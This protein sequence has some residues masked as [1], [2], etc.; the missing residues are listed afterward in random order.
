MTSISKESNTVLCYM[1]LMKL[2]LN[3]CW[4]SGPSFPDSGK[5]FADDNHSYSQDLDIFGSN[6]LF[7]MINTATTYR[8][9]NVLQGFLADRPNSVDEIYKRQEAVSELAP[10][11]GWRQRFQAEALSTSGSMGDPEKL[12]KWAGDFN[13]KYRNPL[14]YYNYQACSCVYTYSLRIILCSAPYSLLSSCCCTHCSVHSSYH[15]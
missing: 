4:E 2:Q 3:D 7:Q 11:L 12:I 15:K 13:R 10:K 1:V 8:G 5:D 6:S 9:R 14:A